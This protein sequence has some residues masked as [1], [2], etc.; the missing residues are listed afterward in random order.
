MIDWRLASMVALAGCG[1]APEE[2]NVP[3]A[4]DVPV[5]AATTT[6]QAA[7][8]EAEARKS[9]FT[10]LDDNC[11]LIEENREEGPYWL[12]RCPGQGGWQVNW[13]ESDLRQGLTLIGGDGEE[14]ELD[15]SSL[16]AKGAFNSLGSTVEWRGPADGTPDVLIARMNVAG[17]AEPSRPDIS[18]LAVV[19]LSPAPCLVAVVEPSSDQNSKAH[20]I[21]DGKLPICIEG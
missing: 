17:G 4:D 5:N 9:A 7:E 12:R 10:K 8:A 15:L 2:R 19:R 21:A 13:S 11:R 6:S 14:A 18:R 1:Q 20:E 16:V 3:V